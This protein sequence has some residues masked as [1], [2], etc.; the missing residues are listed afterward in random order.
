MNYA[1]RLLLDGAPNEALVEVVKALGLFARLPL[2]GRLPA[3]A[4]GLRRGRPTL[5][6]ADPEALFAR[7][8][9][10]GS[11]TA[12]GLAPEDDLAR[13]DGATFDYNARHIRVTRGPAGDESDPYARRSLVLTR[14]G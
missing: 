1:V 12:F 4:L 2:S 8:Q 14:E 7:V 5:V 6:A 13:L 10:L 3:A 11:L 9:T